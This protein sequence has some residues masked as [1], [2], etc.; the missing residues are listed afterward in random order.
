MPAY[1]LYRLNRHSG[2]IDQAEDFHA[3]DD[4]EAIHRVQARD[5]H[6]ET[7]AMELWQGGRKVRRFDALPDVFRAR[8]SAVA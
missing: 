8:P 6:P 7:V 3:S 4:V 5:G 1:R 2:H